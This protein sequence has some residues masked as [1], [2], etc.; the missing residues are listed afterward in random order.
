MLVSS[1]HNTPKLLA[2]VITVDSVWPCKASRSEIARD[3]PTS[4]RAAPNI[5]LGEATIQ[6][7]S[8]KQTCQDA[9]GGCVPSLWE[10][11]GLRPDSG[12]QSGSKEH[13]GFKL[14]GWIKINL[15]SS[16]SLRRSDVR[17]A[18]V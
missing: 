2:V 1:N 3:D 5:I 7:R 18:A 11:C 14:G 13:E 10:E 17:A 9:D 8:H 16:R 4:I 12:I 15:C 6:R